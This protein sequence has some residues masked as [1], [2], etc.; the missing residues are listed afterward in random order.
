MITNLDLE[1]AGLD[2]HERIAFWGAEMQAAA[3]AKYDAWVAHK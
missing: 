2:D 1:K 3:K